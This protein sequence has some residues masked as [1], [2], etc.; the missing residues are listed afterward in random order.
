MPV[1]AAVGVGVALSLLLQLNQEAMD[2]TVVELV[3]TDDQRFRE[4][5]A[6]RH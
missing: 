3:P 4:Q 6:P 2:L 5:P 1:A